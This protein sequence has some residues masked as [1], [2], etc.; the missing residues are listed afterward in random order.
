MAITFDGT[1]GGMTRLGRF[2]KVAYDLRVYQKTTLPANIL[3]LL[4]QFVGYLDKIQD[5]PNLDLA[6]R[7]AVAQ[8]MSGL[9]SDAQN[10]VVQMVKDDIP[11]WSGNL[12]TALQEWIA[13]MV[14]QG[15]TV[16]ACTVGASAAA[17]T[18]LT[19]NGQVVLTTKRGDGLVNELI[20]AEV[21]PLICVLDAQTGGATEGQESFTYTGSVSQSDVWSDTY[22]IGPG[23]STTLN[24]VD[25]AQDNSGGNALVNGDM[26]D[27]TSN[28]PQKWTAFAGVA[29]TDYKKSVAEFYTGSSSLEYVGGSGN[30]NLGIKFNDSALGTA[31]ELL[32]DTT[33]IGSF[34]AKCD[35]VP[36]AGTLIAELVGGDDIGSMSLTADDQGTNNTATFTVSGFSTDWVFKSFVFRTPRVLDDVNCLTFRVETDISSGSSLF[37]SHFALTP[38]TALYSG[39]P[40]IAIFSGNTPFIL[41]DNFVLTM[42][43]NYGGASNLG[44]FQWLFERLFDMRSKGLLLPSAGSPT[45]A[46]TL[47]S[48]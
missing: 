9:Q 8:I 18:P 45:L 20:Y 23:N 26:Q 16:K 21:A 27:F 37:M 17:G 44:T 31:Y 28:L 40:G 2:G 14:D 38:A 34:V 3:S 43:Q 12:T 4:A 39:G 22:P 25:A 42:T 29:G 24:A 48:S 30:P 6:S 11:S 10:V 47:I 35:V 41:N 46:D 7:K 36:A 32:P 13:Q 5:V 33:Y 1:G 19:G 15:E